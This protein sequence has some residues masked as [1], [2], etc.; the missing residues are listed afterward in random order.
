MG[1]MDFFRGKSKTKTQIINSGFLFENS[2][3]SNVYESDIVRACIHAIAEEAS[4]MVLKSVKKKDGRVVENDD[5]L[6]RLFSGKPNE[7]MTMKDM[8]YW[9]AYRLETH[10]NAYWFPEVEVYKFADN[11]IEERVVAIYPI[12]STSEEMTYDDNTKQFYLMFNLANGSQYKIPY[13]EIIH[14]RKH[15]GDKSYYFGAEDR[16][17]LLSKLNI[18]DQVT[19]LMPKAVN[20]SMQIKGILSAKSQMGLEPLKSF[21]KDFEEGLKSNETALGIMDVAGEFTP[22]T[23]NPKIIDKEIL[24]HLKEGILINF[25]TPLEILLGNATEDTWSSFYQKNIEPLKIE[26][27]QAASHVLFSG[28]KLDFGNRIKVYD[29]LVQ[30]FTIKTRLAIVERL[31]PSN[32]LS[33]AEQ[34]ELVGYEPDGGE[35]KVSLNY[36]DQTLANEYQLGF[37]P[38]KKEKNDEDKTKDK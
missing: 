5:D 36:V 7:L 2:F 27:E 6:N 23:I 14:L 4:K 3:G 15:Y 26:I 35:E 28:R 8:L 29:K 19:K 20:A 21:K 13:S 16:K 1:I 10:S 31:G 33:R 18:M 32:Y 30:H 22:V 17:A 12:N 34:R 25:A 24:D 9:T 11:H 38:K 37:V